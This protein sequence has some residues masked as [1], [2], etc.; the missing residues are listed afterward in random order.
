[1]C[2][3]EQHP[4]VVKYANCISD[5]LLRSPIGVSTV[6]K[7]YGIRSNN[8]SRFYSFISLASDL[9]LHILA[10]HIGLLALEALLG[11][12]FRFLYY[13]FIYFTCIGLAC[14]GTCK[15]GHTLN[16][17]FLLTSST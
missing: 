7:I 6:K 17:L 3:L 16:P 14:Y 8:G 15:E 9:N 5:D 12:L 13:T 10:P 4:N 2:T 11:K 1:M